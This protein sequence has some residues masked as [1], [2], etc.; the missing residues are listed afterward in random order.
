MKFKCNFCDD[1]IIIEESKLS[2]SE[3]PYIEILSKND[4]GSYK[5]EYVHRY[6]KCGYRNKYIV[7]V[8]LSIK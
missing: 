7:D 3:K 6:Y 8:N 1:N 5:C 4:N 2:K